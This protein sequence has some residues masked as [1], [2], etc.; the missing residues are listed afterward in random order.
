M[1]GVGFY[2]IH[3]HKPNACKEL[4]SEREPARVSGGEWGWLLQRPLIQMR[5]LVGETPANCRLCAEALLAL[6]PSLYAT[7][8]VERLAAFNMSDCGHTF[9]SQQDP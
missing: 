8:R 6:A 7:A 1:S 5:I 9:I 3:V 2:N 4:P